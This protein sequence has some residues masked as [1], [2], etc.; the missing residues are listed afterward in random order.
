MPARGGIFPIR[1]LRWAAGGSAGHN[2]RGLHGDYLVGERG[3]AEN[4]GEA[5][6]L[7]WKKGVQRETRAGPPSQPHTRPR[8]LLQEL[9]AHDAPTPSTPQRQRSN[10]SKAKFSFC[11]PFQEASLGF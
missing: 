10:V 1:K 8:Q 4:N 9:R 3:N 11:F 6:V 5:V 7:N 2:K